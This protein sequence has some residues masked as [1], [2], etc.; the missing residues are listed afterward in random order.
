[1]A[2]LVNEVVRANLVRMVA[3]ESQERVVSV[4]KL[5]P[6][7]FQDPRVKMAKMDHLENREQMDSQVLQEKGVSLECEEL[8][9]PLV[10]QEKRAP[11]GN[12]VDRALQD[13]EEWLENL[14]ETVTL[15]QQD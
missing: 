12:V 7:V 8:L 15:E 6:Q 9:D 13:P 14:A 5:V 3:R 10:L 1:M 11:L 4:V 2:F